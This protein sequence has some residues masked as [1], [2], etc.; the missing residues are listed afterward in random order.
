[1]LYN[2]SMDDKNKPKALTS[3]VNLVILALVLVG[4]GYFFFQKPVN[5]LKVHFLSVGQ[6]DA[7]LIQTPSGQSVLIDGGPNSSVVGEVEKYMPF[8]QKKIDA[9]ILSHPHAD[10]VAGLVDIAKKYQIGHVYMTGIVHTAPEYL[11]FLKI[12]KD[13]NIQATD[14][15]S[16]DKLDLGNDIRI[17]FL[18]PIK[19]LVGGKIDNLNNSSIVNR[20]VYGDSSVLFTGDL[21]KDSQDEMIAANPNI[22][23]NIL[24][25]PHHGSKDATNPSLV[26]AVSPQ[27]AV[28]E[29]GKNN[30]FGHPTATALQSL[31]GIQVFRTDQDGDVTFNLTKTS[32]NR[33]K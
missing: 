31:V 10:H 6:G 8:Y 22:K 14:V 3:A 2:V 7:E 11:E 4:I 19:T 26:K 9:V 20:L 33:E 1:M 13:K 30:K 12:V 27:F 15:K 17:D 16:G 5:G 32:V 24:K 28:I 18:Y 23:S 21:E 29:V 25:V